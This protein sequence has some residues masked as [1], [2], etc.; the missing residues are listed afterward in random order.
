MRSCDYIYCIEIV[1]YSWNNDGY[2][3]LDQ[4]FHFSI[5]ETNMEYS[6]TKY[7]LLGSTTTTSNIA[8]LHPEYS[9]WEGK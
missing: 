8:F 9:T 5:P 2:H 4:V 6:E 7:A 3:I 1:V